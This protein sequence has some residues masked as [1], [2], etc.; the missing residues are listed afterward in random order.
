MSESIPSKRDKT[1]T[2]REPTP[3]LSVS[4]KSD[5]FCEMSER[6]ATHR[7]YISDDSVSDVEAPPAIIEK[8][9]EPIELS[10]R[11]LVRQAGRDPTFKEKHFKSKISVNYIKDPE[12]DVVLKP[13]PEI[14]EP[15]PDKQSE[16]AD[17]F[18]EKEKEWRMLTL[19]ILVQ[20]RVRRFLTLCRRKRDGYYG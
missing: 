12:P 9:Y 1:P 3:E 11:K 2:P 17:D 15:E 13:E 20:A 8:E 4:S 19:V 10:E 7:N 5:S 6:M 18:T 14:I 16:P